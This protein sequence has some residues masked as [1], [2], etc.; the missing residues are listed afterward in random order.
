MHL[1]LLKEFI[2]QRL[3]DL[4]KKNMMSKQ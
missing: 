4:L 1:M 3:L 2:A